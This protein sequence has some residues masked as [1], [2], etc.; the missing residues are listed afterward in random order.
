MADTSHILVKIV[1]YI[2]LRH[3]SIQYRID[4]LLLMLVI[5]C[6]ISNAL[7]PIFAD[8]DECEISMPCQRN[9]ICTNKFGTFECSAGCGVLEIWENY[10]CVSECINIYTN[11]VK[12]SIAE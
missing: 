1:S 9:E 11:F 4:I 12:F 3:P 8:V 5:Y 10:T 2:N 6:Y 7:N